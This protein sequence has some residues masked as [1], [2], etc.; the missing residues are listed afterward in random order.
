[1]SCLV[2]ESA[3]RL[4][5]ATPGNLCFCVAHGSLLQLRENQGQ[6]EPHDQYPDAKAH[7]GSML[8]CCVYFVPQD[9]KLDSSCLLLPL[10]SFVRKEPN[11]HKPISQGR[12]FL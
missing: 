10:H 4:P 8:E 7:E 6:P 3:C 12:L 1:M 2:G 5:Q 9:S 11:L